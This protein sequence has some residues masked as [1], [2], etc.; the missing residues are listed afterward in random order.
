MPNGT[1][2]HVG[3]LEP[4]SK[5]TWLVSDT[6]LDGEHDTYFVCWLGLEL[7]KYLLRLGF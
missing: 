4:Q 1:D 3:F 5:H 6:D 2:D 7:L